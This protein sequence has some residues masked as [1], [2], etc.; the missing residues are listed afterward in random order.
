MVELVVIPS[1]DKNLAVAHARLLTRTV[2]QVENELIEKR[3]VGFSAMVD[4]RLQSVHLESMPRREDFR[5]ARKRIE[6]AIGQ[7][8]L[9][10][11][12]SSVLKETDRT[13]V[14]G[15]SSAPKSAFCWLLDNGR[16]VP[17]HI[18]L[19]S[20]GRLPDNDIILEEDIVSRR[21]CA[22]VIHS[23]TSAEV[24]DIA[25]KNGTSVNGRKLAGSSSLTD[26]DEIVV[27]NHTLIFVMRSG[28]PTMEEGVQ[29]R[30][31]SM[32]GEHTLVS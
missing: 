12:S 5:R 31:G 7:N 24:L 23:D 30:N 28:A 20:I 29:H 25:S 32:S 9:I 18:G 27:A 1:A 22:V 13:H 15:N 14:S 11:Q 8:T 16:Q 2:I 6:G 10:G 21:H 19:N 3:P 17:L 26:G 4:P